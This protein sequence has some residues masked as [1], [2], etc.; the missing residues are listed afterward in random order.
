[1]KYLRRAPDR[2]C[3][4]VVACAVLHNIATI[5]KERLPEILSEERWE[6]PAPVQGPTDGRTLRNLYRDTYFS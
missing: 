4:I 1:M 3:D 5:W 2:A 6:K